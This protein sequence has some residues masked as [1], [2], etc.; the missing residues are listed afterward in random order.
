MPDDDVLTVNEIAEDLGVNISTV[1]AWITQE[2]LPAHRD[3]ADTR[4][5]LAFRRDVQAFLASASR[6]DIGRPRTRGGEDS[7]VVARDD[8]SD[9]PEEATLNLAASRRAGGDGSGAA[10]VSPQ[11]AFEQLRKSDQQWN[12]AIRAFDDYPTRLRALAKAADLRSR[13]LTLAHLANIT[14]NPR[15]GASSVSALAFE[16]SPKRD[17]PGPR[18]LWKRFDQAVRGLGEA[19]EQ[20]DLPTL[21][22]A[23]GELA[24]I[25]SEL[26][27]ACEGDSRRLDETG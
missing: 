17:R 8:W 6:P 1:R 18:A 10:I 14:G 2:R 20:G 4:R 25:A 12:E 7:E 15:Q 3:P 23:F 24:P 9:V 13:T 11:N 5:W 27:D 21:A 22:N 16:L 19:L 26:A